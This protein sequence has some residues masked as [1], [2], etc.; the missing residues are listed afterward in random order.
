[1]SVFSSGES[2]ARATE[3]FAAAA[4]SAGEVPDPAR[5]A[6]DQAAAADPAQALVGLAALRDHAFSSGKLELLGEVNVEGSPAAAAD[7]QTAD[8]LRASGLV[9]AGFTTSLSGVA[10]EEGATGARAVVRATSA[11]SPYEEKDA[12]GSVVATGGASAVQPLRL[13]LVSVNGKWRI[14]EIKPGS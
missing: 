1:M 5:A 4:G 7:R 13:L 12:Q 6:R 10:A 9:L 2:P 3:T 14:S 8:R 11:T